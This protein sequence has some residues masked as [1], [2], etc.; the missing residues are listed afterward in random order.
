MKGKAKGKRDLTDGELRLMKAI[1]AIG[2]GA[3]TTQILEKFE[4]WYGERLT[5]QAVGGYLAKLEKKGYLQILKPDHYYKVY[6][7]LIDKKSYMKK[8]VRFWADFWGESTV[9]YAMMGLNEKDELTEEE[10]RK[11]KGLLDGI[12]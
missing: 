8:Q 1:W 2:E 5:S 10:I 7:P 11:L 9:D 3:T 4:E 6:K 12:D